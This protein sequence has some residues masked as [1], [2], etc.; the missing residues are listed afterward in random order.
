MVERNILQVRMRGPRGVSTLSPKRTASGHLS[1]LDAVRALHRSIGNRAVRR[2]AREGGL[3]RAPLPGVWRAKLQHDGRLAT[4]TG[5]LQA[6]LAVSHP[7]ASYASEAGHV[8]PPITR[9]HPPS[10]LPGPPPTSRLPR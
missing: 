7:P 4:R 5:V 3:S 8:A 9:K 6:A 10:A 2:L 1:P